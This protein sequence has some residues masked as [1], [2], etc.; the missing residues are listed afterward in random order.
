[1]LFGDLVQLPMADAKLN[2]LL[3]HRFDLEIIKPPIINADVLVAEGKAIKLRLGFRA[4]GRRRLGIPEVRMRVE[5]VQFLELFDPAEDAVKGSA[6]K[7][8]QL[9]V[10]CITNIIIRR[11]F[12]NSTILSA[13]FFLT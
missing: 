4:A 3:P 8:S 12:Q 9:H 10:T 6:Q 2:N 1:M 7:Y 5:H 13:G 11:M